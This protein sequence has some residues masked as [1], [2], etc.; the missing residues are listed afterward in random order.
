LDL[1]EKDLR[2][3]GRVRA[4]ERFAERVLLAVGVVPGGV[5]A[6]APL[7]TT[8]GALFVAW[9]AGA[10]SAVRRAGEKGGDDDFE[11]WFAHRIG[12]RAVRAAQ[13]PERLVAQVEDAI[14]G[15]SRR[16]RFDL[17]R[18]SPFEQEVLRKTLEIPRGEVRPYAWVAREI[19]RPR[20]VRAVGTALGH[21][22]IP[23]LIPCHRVVRSDGA[24]G[25]Y[26]MG[27]PEVKR[28]IL[29]QEGV[30]AD[31]LEALGAR[32][33]RFVGSRTTHVFCLPTCRH[34]QRIQE[35]NRVALRDES[36][37]RQAGFRPCTRCR[38]VAAASSV[39]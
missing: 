8:V 20:A 21:N 18:L 39:S 9:N 37:A 23:V 16:L 17:G 3:L 2:D 35:P 28:A 25:E 30:D 22:P 11:S 26:S 14:A 19:G 27:G 12:R 34:A 6:Y 32:G 38:P 1:L 7:E 13:V 31:W 36:E 24:L 4:P 5:D 10:V 29:S 33:T 15:R